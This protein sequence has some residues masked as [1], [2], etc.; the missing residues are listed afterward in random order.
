MNPTYSIMHPN[1]KG[2]GSAI[3]FE[4]IPARVMAEGGMMAT[5]V[6]QATVGAVDAATGKRTFPTFDWTNRIT[7]KFTVSEVAEMLQVLQGLK[8]AVGDSKGFFHRTAKGATIITFAHKMEAGA[9]PG[10][11][12]WLNRKPTEG[13]QQNIGIFFSMNKAFALSKALETALFYMMFGIPE[14]YDEPKVEPKK[15]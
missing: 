2:T 13:E 12:L 14:K 10:Y 1:G 7:V 15:N 8:R 4:M 6:R 3:K 5:F 11:A 9:N